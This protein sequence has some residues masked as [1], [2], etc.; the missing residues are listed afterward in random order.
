MMGTELLIQDFRGGLLA[1]RLLI[2]RGGEGRRGRYNTGA[3]DWRYNN[4]YDL[5]N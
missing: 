5:M 4:D 3:R 2:R 1:N